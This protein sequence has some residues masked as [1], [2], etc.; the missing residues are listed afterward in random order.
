M[1]AWQQR[2][3]EQDRALV[4]GLKGQLL[5][6]SLPAS[7]LVRNRRLTSFVYLPPGYDDA[8]N[9]TRLYSVAYLLHGAPGGVRDCFVNAR[10]HR[11]AEKMILGGRISPMILVGWEAGGP[12]GLSDPVYY[13]NREDGYRMEDF[14]LQVLVPWVDARFRTQPRPESRALIGFSAGGFG[15]ANLGLKH[16]EV[17]RVL[18]SHAGFFNPADDIQEMSR[19][20]GP[21]DSHSAA[22]QANDPIAEARR[23]PNGTRLHFYMDVG[24]EDSLLGEFRQMERELKVRGVDFE[25]HVFKGAHTWEY[26][27]RHYEDSLAFADSRWKEMAAQNRQALEGA[28]R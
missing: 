5:Q 14:V 1:S 10:A 7:P 3:Q 13:L 18:A 15:A 21:R 26:L 16:P 12:G 24:R 11:V 19:I 8:A 25:A 20:L 4:A 27:E 28:P 17:W 22:W 6:I 9:A 2:A 23:I